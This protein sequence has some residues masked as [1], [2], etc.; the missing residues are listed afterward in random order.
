[1]NPSLNKNIVTASFQLPYQIMFYKVFHCFELILQQTS[2]ANHFII[3]DFDHY[4]EWVRE[5]LKRASDLFIHI[6]TV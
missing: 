6:P 1:M 4:V 5:G 2:L 3:C